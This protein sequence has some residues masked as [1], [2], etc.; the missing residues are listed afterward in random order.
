MISTLALGLFAPF[1]NHMDK[2]VILSR[3]TISAFRAQSFNRT[4][5]FIKAICLLV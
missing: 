5:N 1:L 4:N 2:L 3:K